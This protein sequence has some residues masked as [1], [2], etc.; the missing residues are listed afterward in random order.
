MQEA[1]TYNLFVRASRDSKSPSDARNDI[2]VKIDGDTKSVLPDGSP[3]MVS[4]N[5][6]IKI[7]G[8][9]GT[10]AGQWDHA[11]KFDSKGHAVKNPDSEVVLSEG[12]HT[13]TF[14]GRSEGFHID[15][16]QLTKGAKPDTSLVSSKFV[17]D[18]KPDPKPQPDP[19]PEP[20]PD[21][22]PEPKPEPENPSVSYEIDAGGKGDTG[23]SGGKT[24]ATSAAIAGT[25]DDGTYQTER[26][27]D[28]DYSLA[29]KNGTYDVTLKFAETYFNAAGKRVFD[30]KAEGKTVVDDLD[31][32]K[33]AGG[34]NVAHDIVVPVK[35]K[36]GRLDL[37]F[38]G[39]VENATVSGIEVGPQTSKPD[40]KP[41]PKPEPENPSVSY[42]IDAGGK[43]DTGFSGGKTYATSAAIAGTKDDGTYQTE[44]YGDF[45]YSLAV[46]NGTYDV[47]LKFAETYFNAAGKRVFDVKAEG[48][49]VVDDLDLWKAAGGK[50]VAHDIV[51]P[52]KVKDG[53]LD[54]DFLGEIENA[55]VSG[56]EVA[57]AGQGAARGQAD[58]TAPFDLSGPNLGVD[59]VFLFG[60]GTDGKSA[61][62]ERSG[63]RSAW[64]T[65]V[66][67]G[68][69][70]S[71]TGRRPAAR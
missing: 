21:P 51:V 70:T 18:D 56:I 48:K 40:P 20:K 61:P 31:L 6:F 62:V 5:G 55:T 22:K 23:F 15:S 34:K 65:W 33:A 60:F 24:Y 7:H 29:V 17:T 38:L 3:T 42:E 37:D 71:A 32:W 19:K 63:E 2:W 58:F 12:F 35:V 9:H 54:L 47:T 4:S 13:I 30:V 46:K 26:Y 28:F 43:G 52:V 53:R 57:K 59:D 44:R 49:T 50:N 16:F 39:E 8:L 10:K 25:K 68:R 1:G 64:T 66:R 41:E 45:D 69:S 11:E 67:P 14:A 27:G 36:D